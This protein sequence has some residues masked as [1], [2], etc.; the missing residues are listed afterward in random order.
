M[1]WPFRSTFWSSIKPYIPWRPVMYFLAIALYGVSITLL[2][3]RHLHDPVLRSLVLFAFPVVY[4]VLVTTVLHRVVRQA[5]AAR[6]ADRSST[7]HGG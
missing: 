3:G 6:D 5:T 7:A 1:P 4:L 2:F